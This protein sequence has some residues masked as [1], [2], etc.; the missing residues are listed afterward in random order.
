MS[1]RPARSEDCEVIVI[2]AGPYG[3]AVTA[4][5]RQHDIATRTFGD[6]MSFW[7][8]HMPRGMMLRSPWNATHIADPHREFSLDAYISGH[9]L[10]RREPLKLDTFIDY[11]L[12]FQGR[13]A[14]DIDRRMVVRVEASGDGFRA[15]TADGDAVY[16]DR[17]VI[18][19]G[20]ARQQNRPPAFEN[21]P[22]ALASHTCEH[23]DL[24]VFRGRRVAVVGRGQSA[25][26][27]AV[28]LREAGADVEIICRSD[29]HWLG[30]GARGRAMTGWLSERLASPSGVGPFPLNW[31]AERPDAARLMP[32]DAR[33]WFNAR[34]LRAGAAGWL[35]PR[36]D[37]VRVLANEHIH[38]A[39][40]TGERI[41]L[42]LDRGTAV[43]D[44]VLLGTGYRTDIAKLGILG[45]DLLNKVACQDGA[46]KLGAGFE[47]SVPGLHFV[48][49]SAVASFG[50]LMRFIAGTGFAARELSQSVLEHRRYAATI[51]R[52]A[53]VRNP[54]RNP[55]D[56][57]VLEKTAP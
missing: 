50:P 24:G 39:V 14:P 21:V 18:A 20:L 19:T 45:S 9:G 47:S 46:P 54:S 42:M 17:V 4:H 5:L 36:F 44:H 33:A 30:S 41:A 6:P 25:C 29:I 53:S 28:L 43:F 38:D 27:S 37:G 2:G 15:V 8:R 56:A 13:V 40:V 1:N 26:E 12:W 3:S 32:A 35:R 16:S 31:L 57:T 52:R 22:A 34:C 51:H 7:R 55:A 48:G 11:G 49:A 23:D 10:R